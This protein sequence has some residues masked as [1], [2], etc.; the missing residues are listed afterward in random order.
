[1]KLLLIRKKKNVP[2]LKNHVNSPP[3][4]FI[5]IHFIYS[6]SQLSSNRSFAYFHTVS[7]NKEPGSSNNRSYV[8]FK[9]TSFLEPMRQIKRNV[10][11]GRRDTY[12]TKSHE[13]TCPLENVQFPLS[14]SLSLSLDCKIDI[15]RP[16]TTDVSPFSLLT[17][18]RRNDFEA[19]AVDSVLMASHHTSLSFHLVVN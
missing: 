19:F 9:S 7:V 1:M 2:K 16:S 8:E 15:R 11:R 14:P 6:T 18:S 5:H 13:R 3:L 17:D 12:S 10:P 4:I